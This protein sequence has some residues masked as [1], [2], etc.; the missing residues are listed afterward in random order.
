MLKFYLPFIL[1]IDDHS[2]IVFADEKPIYEIDVYQ[3]VRRDVITDNTPIHE[4]ESANSKNKYSILVAAV[5]IKGGTVPPVKSF[6]I[7]KCTDSSIFL[8]FIRL[9]LESRV[10]ERG[11]VYVFDNCTIHKFGD[12]IGTQD[13]CFVNTVF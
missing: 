2:S 13:F 4:L 8:R 3:L 11:V 5:N 7:E 12:N 6:L 9:L 1:S 10:L